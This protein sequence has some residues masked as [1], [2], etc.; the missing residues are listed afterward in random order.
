MRIDKFLKV[1]RVLKRRTL[2]QEACDNGKVYINGREAK[3]GRQV[4]EGDVVEIAFASGTV[5]FRVLKALEN[6]KKDQAD[7]MYELITDTADAAVNA[8]N[9]DA[10][11]PSAAPKPAHA[12]SNP[13]AASGS[14]SSGTQGGSAGGSS[15]GGR[16]DS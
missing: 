14:V 4:K 3:P 6:V 12:A 8:G 11:S 10:A 5:K 9:A 13:A 15:A 16:H 2:A 7:S 1:S